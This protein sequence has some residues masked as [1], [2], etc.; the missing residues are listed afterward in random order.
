MELMHVFKH[1]C[2]ALHYNDNHYHEMGNLLCAPWESA[3]DSDRTRLP[4]CWI[5][6]GRSQ[7]IPPCPGAFRSCLEQG[8]SDKVKEHVDLLVFIG[9][10][11]YL[12]EGEPGL[13][14]RPPEYCIWLGNYMLQNKDSQYAS[15]QGYEEPK[16]R[17]NQMLIQTVIV[18]TSDFLDLL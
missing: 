3:S 17:L 16:N 15:H 9:T 5:F 1:N 12:E 7:R 8:Y 18:G 10:R 4:A 11:L 14:V 2:E 13:G 6:D